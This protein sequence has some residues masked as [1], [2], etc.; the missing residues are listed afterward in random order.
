M[1]KIIAKLEK[2]G[3]EA[4]VYSAESGIQGVNIIQSGNK[5]APQIT[6]TFGAATLAETEFTISTTSYGGLTVDEIKEV[7]AGYEKAV[8]A[9]EYFKEILVAIEKAEA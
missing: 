6:D 3:Y 2:N 5:Y 1:R 4:L 9:V 7:M 8:E